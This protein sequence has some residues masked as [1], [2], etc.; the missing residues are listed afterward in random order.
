MVNLTKTD[1][2]PGTESQS[3]PHHG[4]KAANSESNPAQIDS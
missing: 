1:H 3:S 2:I 4:S